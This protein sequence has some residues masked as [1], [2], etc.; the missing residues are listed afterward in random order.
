MYISSLVSK[1]SDLASGLGK[2]DHEL[3]HP[4]QQ[5][6]LVI[7][8]EPIVQRA[9]VNPLSTGC[10]PQCSTEVSNYGALYL[11][12]CQLVLVFVPSF[13]GTMLT[14]AIVRRH[15]C[16]SFAVHVCTVT[17]AA[18]HVRDFGASRS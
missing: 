12:C 10:P 6:T 13:L 5:I 11:Y 17:L 16:I 1:I 7:A 9:L 4:S 8:I 15:S 3:R 14:S 18:V 2:C